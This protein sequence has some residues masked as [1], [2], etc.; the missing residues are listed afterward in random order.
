VSSPASP[1]ESR[2]SRVVADS[3]DAALFGRQFSGIH[4]GAVVGSIVTIKRPRYLLWGPT[5]IIAEAMEAACKPGTLNLSE[6]TR[7]H[8]DEESLG[9]MGLVLEEVE[10]SGKTARYTRTLY[11]LTPESVTQE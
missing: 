11:R 9:R 6:E 2:F 4:T 1:A 7:R 5:P 8:L 3:R 10:H